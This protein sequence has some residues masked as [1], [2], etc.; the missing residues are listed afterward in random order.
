MTARPPGMTVF[1]I[2]TPEICYPMTVGSPNE[3]FKKPFLSPT[4]ESPT[5]GYRGHTMNVSIESMV[6]GQKVVNYPLIAPAG[7]Q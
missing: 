5:A 2:I 7:N 4:R 6:D 1:S 3:V